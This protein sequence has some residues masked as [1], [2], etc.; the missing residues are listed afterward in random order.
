MSRDL[1]SVDGTGRPLN[2][3]RPENYWARRI[4]R[5]IVTQLTQG[6]SIREITLTLA[7]GSTLGVF[8]ILGVTTILCFVAGYL[9]KL[10]Q[11]ILQAANWMVVWIHPVLL[12]LFVRLGERVVGAEAMPFVPTELVMEFNASPTAFMKRFGMTGLHGILGW[13]LIAPATFGFAYWQM[14]VLLRKVMNRIQIDSRGH[15]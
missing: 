8:P 3:S 5:P 6:V 10:N 12:L 7:L 2:Q 11:V 13:S 1:V 4:V 14:S 9:L 15:D